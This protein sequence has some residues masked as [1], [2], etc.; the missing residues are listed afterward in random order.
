M[1]HELIRRAKHIIS[2]IFQRSI[3]KISYCDPNMEWQ[4]NQIHG[5]GMFC[6][7]IR[8]ILWEK[9]TE[10]SCLIHSD[11][12]VQTINPDVHIVHGT[13][14]ITDNR[15]T[16]NCYGYPYTVTIHMCKGIAHFINI[17]GNDKEKA[18][19]RIR[20]RDENVYFLTASQIIYI[21]AFHND[22]LWHCRE[23]TLMSRGSLKSL[24]QKLPDNFCRIHRCYIVNTNHISMIK[25]FELEMDNGDHLM[26][27]QRNYADIKRYLLHNCEWQTGTNINS[28]HAQCARKGECYERLKSFSGN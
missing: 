6:P 28:D 11:Y 13:F 23:H 16:N 14:C 19:F 17:G 9:F 10:T 27:P 4:I 21:E 5:Y 8:K 1:R 26:I 18:L 12:R 22:R 25:K 2:E 3:N 24:Q 15:D 20:N 7:Q